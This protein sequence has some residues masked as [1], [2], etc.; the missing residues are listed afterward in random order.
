MSGVPFDKLQPIPCMEHR[1]LLRDLNASIPLRFFT[2][3]GDMHLHTVE[4]RT[5]G[6]KK[7]KTLYALV[8]RQQNFLSTETSY[9]QKTVVGP[10]GLEPIWV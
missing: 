2:I 10:E 5:P 9:A 8:K 3:G 6:F 1:A 4:R 7:M